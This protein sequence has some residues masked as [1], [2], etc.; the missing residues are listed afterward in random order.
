M[1]FTM[2]SLGHI[3]MIVAPFI[4]TAILHY[5]YI[6]KTWEEKRKI[7]MVLSMIAIHILILR[8][9]EIFIK[10]GYMFDHELLPLQV[11]HFANFVLYYAFWKNSKV[12]FSMVF[13]LNMLVAFLSVVFADGLANYTTIL[14]FR[15][16]AYISGHIIIVVITMWAFLNG[17]IHISKKAFIKTVYVVNIMIIIS[18][19]VNNFMYLIY[20]KYSNYFY[21]EHPEGGTPLEW[22]FDWG[23]EFT[24]GFFKINYFYVI[25]MLVFFPLVAYLFYLLSKVLNRK[26]FNREEEVA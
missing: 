21:T 6:D 9:L 5:A 15:G 11:C 18:L 7:G 8:N 10:N 19:F 16:F 2:W 23:K 13:T 26:I 25:C 1:T 3:L 24:Y 20:G 22:F 4:I 14:N 17:F 12:A